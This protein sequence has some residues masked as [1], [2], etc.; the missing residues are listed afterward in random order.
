MT[1]KKT[2]TT[3][4]RLGRLEEKVKKIDKIDESLATIESEEEKVEKT[5][6]K[7]EHL[8][9]KEESEIDKIEN[10][11]KRIEKV[12]MKIGKFTVKRTHLL[13]FARSFAGAFLGVGVGLSLR[14]VPAIA[15]SLSWFNVLGILF[16]VF[17]ISGILL[18]KQEKENIKKVGK[19]LVFKK[20]FFIYSL[21]IVVELIAF[22]LFA[23]IP[24]DIFGL[25][26]ALIVGSYPAMAGA[27]TFT[28][29]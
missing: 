23:S 10:E 18:Y 29:I 16:F 20:L 2:D 17:F 8:V 12:L 22:A 25:V 1:R 6:Q 15:E 21:C 5:E 24:S 4:K 14:G 27:I 7:L 28:L 9:E 11:E 26:K 3:K 19:I 13:E